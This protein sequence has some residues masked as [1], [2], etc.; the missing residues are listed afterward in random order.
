MNAQLVRNI[1]IF[2]DTPFH[3]WPTE[4]PLIQV[5]KIRRHDGLES[6]RVSTRSEIIPR[7]SK[8]GSF[9]ASF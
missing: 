1:L 2:S 5:V 8:R 4:A 9:S 7:C 6:L 3:L